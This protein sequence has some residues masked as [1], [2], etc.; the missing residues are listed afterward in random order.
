MLALVVAA[1]GCGNSVIR[2]SAATVNGQEITQD[3]LDVE[4][5]AIKG[6]PQYVSLLEQ[7]GATIRGSGLGTLSNQFVGQV[8]TRQIFLELIRQEVV[9]RKLTVTPADVAATEAEVSEGTGGDAIYRAF[10]ARYREVLKRRQAQVAKLREGFAGPPPDEAAIQRF[11]EEN[12]PQ[13]VQTC[14]SHIL[15]AVA[16]EGGQL[17][18]A[19]TTAQA[20]SLRAQAEA[21]RAEIAAG[22]DFAALAA[23]HS[24]D[25]GSKANGGSLECGPEGRF[26][27]GAPEIDLALASLAVDDVSTPVQTAFGFH[28]LKVTSRGPQSLEEATP[29]IRQQLEGQSDEGLNTFF[30]EAVAKAKVTVN[31][32]YGQFTKE[33]P[34]PGIIPPDAPTTTEAGAQPPGQQVPNPFAP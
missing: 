30:E 25:V 2:P 1:S 29:A 12:Q 14:V 32:R 6:N 9:R 10:P 34:Q 31:P 4:L 19:A 23:Q 17:D 21:V 18:Q 27:S 26:A 28:L 16:G 13:F 24:A 3:A 22:G 8:L 11:Y 15:F 7:S 5:D 20:E 33:G